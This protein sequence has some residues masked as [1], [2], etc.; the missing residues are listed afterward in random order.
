MY[1]KNV[2]YSAF[3]MIENKVVGHKFFVTENAKNNWCNKQYRVHGE[4]VTVEVY[5][6]NTHKRLEIWHA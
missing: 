3:A 4:D 6:F 1:S 5:D 2:K